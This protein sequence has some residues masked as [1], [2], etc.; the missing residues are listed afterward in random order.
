LKER[1][2][3]MDANKNGILE[4][5]EFTELMKKFGFSE[6]EIDI[7]MTALDLNN[8]GS[9]EYSEFVTGCTQFDKANM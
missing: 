2:M 6:G 9:I 4:R 5:D 7:M 3:E 1:F 8:D